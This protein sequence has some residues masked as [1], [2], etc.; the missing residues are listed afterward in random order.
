MLN[1]SSCDVLCLQEI[2]ILDTTITCLSKIHKDYDY[3]G[4]SGIDSKHEI[5][6]GRPKEGVAI[7]YKKSLSKLISFITLS[8]RRV[9]AINIKMANNFSC[10][11]LNVYLPCDNYSANT[12]TREYEQCVEY[13]DRRSTK[14]NRL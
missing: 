2:W 3:Y 4:N 5:L 14:Y 6:K 8:H 1:S 12:V 11:L 10:M 13:I 7:P 9:C